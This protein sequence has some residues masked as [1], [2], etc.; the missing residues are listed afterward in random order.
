MLLKAASELLLQVSDLLALLCHVCITFVVFTTDRFRRVVRPFVGIFSR[1]LSRLLRRRAVSEHA[2]QRLP[3]LILGSI[4]HFTRI[5]LKEEPSALAFLTI[6]VICLL[7]FS[8]LAVRYR[9]VGA[10]LSAG[11]R[12][13]LRADAV[14]VQPAFSIA[15]IGILHL[16][17]ENLQRQRAIVLFAIREA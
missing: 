4:E 11:G 15:R 13:R 10:V 5:L 12:R 2:G 9:R 6:V 8:L 17:H 7:L 14:Q 16:L 1:I 3:R